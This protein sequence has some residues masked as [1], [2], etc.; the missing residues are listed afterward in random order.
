M[1]E[2]E[3]VNCK[4]HGLVKH[5]KRKDISTAIGWRWRCQICETEHARN[6]RRRNK[7]RAVDIKGGC[8]EVCG[9]NKCLASL[10]FHHVDPK[11]KEGNV[12]RLLKCSWERVEKEIDKC[13]LVCR[14]CHGEIHHEDL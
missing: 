14:N 12:K 9:Y 10:T 4:K 5:N 6:R 13:V 7:Q 2:I 3:I 8:C 1:N 11:K